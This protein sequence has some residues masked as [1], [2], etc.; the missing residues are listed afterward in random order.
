MPLDLDRAS[1]ASAATASAIATLGSPMLDTRPP[2]SLVGP[3]ILQPSSSSVMS[4]PSFDRARATATM[5]SHSL[6]R[7]SIAPRSSV[8]PSARVAATASTGSSSIIR[9]ISQGW[10][11]AARRWLEWT[12][13]VA[14]G[15]PPFSPSCSIE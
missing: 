1:A 8:T 4:A 12:V 9:G 15:S 14:D 13:M 11:S 6:K 7:S 10:I 2:P 3:A 5:R